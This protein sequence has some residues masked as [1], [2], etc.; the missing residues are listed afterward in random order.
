MHISFAIYRTDR[1]HDQ[2][3]CGKYLWRSSYSRS[4]VHAWLIWILAGNLKRKWYMYLISLFSLSEFKKKVLSEDKGSQKFALTYVWCFEYRKCIFQ[5]SEFDIL[6][7]IC[8]ETQVNNNDTSSWFKV[9]GICNELSNVMFKLTCGWLMRMRLMR[10]SFTPDSLASVD[11]QI[12]LWT[13][14]NW[15]AHLFFANH[16]SSEE[17]LAT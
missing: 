15:L 8:L 13:P 1:I 17:T 2:W 7:C 6:V 4:Y 11:H 9:F 10:H 12:S 5:F 3:W 16:Y 14:F